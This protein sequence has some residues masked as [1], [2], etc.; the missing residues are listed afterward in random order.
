MNYE[1]LMKRAISLAGQY[2][3]TAK[4]NPVVGFVI[5]KEKTIIAPGT[6]LTFGNN[7][8]SLLKLNM[9]LTKL[10]AVP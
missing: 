1:D 3:Y 2:K 7:V 6:F 5:V 8:N 4:P 10:L 9:S